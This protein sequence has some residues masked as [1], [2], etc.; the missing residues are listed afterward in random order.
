MPLSPGEDRREL[1]ANCR[2]RRSVAGAR[3]NAAGKG[4]GRRLAPDARMRSPWLPRLRPLSRPGRP[5]SGPRPPR[6][7]PAPNVERDGEGSRGGR[8]L[9]PDPTWQGGRK[10]APGVAGEMRT[11]AWRGARAPG[12]VTRWGG[13]EA[14]GRRPAQ[15]G[16][17]K[18][19][20]RRGG[21][22]YG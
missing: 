21:E 7:R 15:Q 17:E 1:L 14:G 5:R 22:R 16:G 4:G 20:A 13:E 2:G 12:A 18:D 6:P 11:N 9:A 8:R 3:S 19:S 10:P